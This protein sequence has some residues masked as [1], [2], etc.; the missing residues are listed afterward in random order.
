MDL[1]TFT[2]WVAP[3]LT[4]LPLIA[5]AVSAYQFIAMQKASTRQ[6]Q[7]ENFFETLKRI[8]NA[9]DDQKNPKSAILQRA[10]V[11]ELRKY[12]E[13]REF[14]VRL[15]KNCLV[16]FQISIEDPLYEEFVLTEAHFSKKWWCKI[17]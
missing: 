9:G 3:M 10:A 16:L 14:I 6:K 12:P 15:C 4:I 7:F 2:D 1:K 11:F 5:L 13:N 17:F 8:N